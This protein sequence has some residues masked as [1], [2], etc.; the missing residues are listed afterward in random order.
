VLAQIALNGGE[1]LETPS[2]IKRL[3]IQDISP[4][5]SQLLATSTS[6]EGLPLDNAPLWALPLP[7][8]SP[9]RLRTTSN[10]FMQYAARWSPDGQR[11]VSSRGSD[12][13][14]SAADGSQPVR[15]VTVQGQP[16]EPVFSPR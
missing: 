2:P 14:V 16:M 10:G 3:L 1:T 12:L 6:D 15:I 13:W 5:H 11:L 7:A 9:R 4:D 8:G